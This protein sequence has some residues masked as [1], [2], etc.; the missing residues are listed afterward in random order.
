[1]R[2]L[3]VDDDPKL[4]EYV[5]AGLRDS[6]I[7]ADTAES[8]ESAL[9]ILRGGGKAFDLI[10]LDVMLPVKSGWDLLM[11]LREE[12]RETPVIFVT[13]RDAVDER[14]KGLR[15]GADD[16]IIKPF[17][18]S[19]LVAR[20]EVVIRRRRSLAPIE[21]RD[22]KLDLAKR[23][24]FRGG[25]RIDLSPR[26]FDL[27]LALVRA[28]GGVVTRATLLRDVWGFLREPETNLIDVHVGRLRRKLDRYGRP[29][30]ATVRGEGYRLANED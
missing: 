18:F 3:V 6:G 16:Y 28:D 13:A 8:G 17:A 24:A 21:I 27:L 5:S 19:E 10:L 4:R 29:L 1:M 2:I 25:H 22:L 7:E 30:I 26:E 9:E 12:G 15:L 23:V 14:V 11:E 20:I